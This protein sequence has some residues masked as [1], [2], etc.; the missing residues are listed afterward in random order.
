MINRAY[1]TVE[2]KGMV[3]ASGKRKF[4]G[5]ASTPSPD[6]MG[7]IVEPKGAV[8]DLPMPLLWQHN[9][10][11]PIGWVNSAKMTD[12]G[13]Q[14]DGEVAVVDGPQCLVD[15]LDM[16]W[17]MLKSGLVKGLSIGFN[18]LEYS[19]LDT[20]GYRFIKWAWHEL[21]A[22]TIPANAEASIT[23]IKSAD[24]AFLASSGDQGRRILRLGASLPGVSGPQRRKG[25]VYLKS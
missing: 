4:T 6:R 14:I 25:V 15:R 19:R 12:A 21:S 17:G 3:D 23:S 10:R 22:V 2:I 9:S 24:A 16:A 8:Y 1:T 18:P 5:I 13:I 20:G 7:D 11:D